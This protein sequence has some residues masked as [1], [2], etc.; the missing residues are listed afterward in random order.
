MAMQI[1][2][3]P[4]RTDVQVNSFRDQWM[5]GCL[6]LLQFMY[7]TK[8]NQEKN[9]SCGYIVPDKYTRLEDNEQPIG[10]A[11]KNTIFL[12]NG[13]NFQTAFIKVDKTDL[14]NMYT[15]LNGAHGFTSDTIA[16]VRGT[17]YQARYNSYNNKDRSGLL[18][19]F[20]G[21]AGANFLQFLR[22][23]NII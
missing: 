4:G 23:K 19:F 15:T 9:R 14:V 6:Y 1:I 10:G 18:H 16:P 17:S 13:N 20:T 12:A 8:N 11:E 2:V 5:N 7:M 3:T 22:T 21:L